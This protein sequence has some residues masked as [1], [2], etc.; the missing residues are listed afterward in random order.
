MGKTLFKKNQEHFAKFL[1]MTKL[2][3]ILG[4]LCYKKYVRA[5]CIDFLWDICKNKGSGTGQYIKKKSGNR[6]LSVILKRHLYES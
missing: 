3:S 6:F 5:L 4:F 1:S 2:L